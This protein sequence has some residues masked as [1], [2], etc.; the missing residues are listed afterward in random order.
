[1]NK[2]K[3]KSLVL[4]NFLEY[5]KVNAISHGGVYGFCSEHPSEI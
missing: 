1:M 2:D 4:Y 3:E 5:H